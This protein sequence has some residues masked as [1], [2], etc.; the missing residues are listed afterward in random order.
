MT[1][2]SQS[3]WKHVKQEGM[4][5]SDMA[6]HHSSKVNHRM[7]RHL[8]LSALVLASIQTS[9]VSVYANEMSADNHDSEAAVQIFR[10]KG[11]TDPDE[12]KTGTNAAGA[13]ADQIS[14]SS[15]TK[16]ASTAAASENTTAEDD[17]HFVSIKG[18][19]TTDKNYA[20]DGATGTDSMVIGIGS[21]SS[22][23]NSTVIGKNNSLERNLNG[24]NDSVVVGTNLEVKGIHN[25]VFGTDYDNYDHRETKVAGDQNTVLGVGNVVGYTTERHGTEWTYTKLSDHGDDANVVVGMNNT[26]N[27]GSIV[28][29][30]SSTAGDLGTSLGHGNTI[31]GKQWGLALGNWLT[32]KGEGAVAIGGAGKWAQ[33]TVDG[34]YAIAVGANTNAKSDYTISMGYGSNAEDVC[35]ISVGYK[36]RAAGAKSIAMGLS[37]AAE[38]VQSIALGAGATASVN[39][40]IALGSLSAADRGTAN[41]V[42]W[43]PDT[44]N[45]STATSAVWKP[46]GGEFSVGNY[47][48][49]VTRQI[50]NVAAGTEDT[51]AVNV[52]QLKRAMKESADARKVINERINKDEGDSGTDTKI[53]A[54]SGKYDKSNKELNLTLTDSTGKTINGRIN[55]EDLVSS[56]SGVAKDTRNTVAAGD[57]VTIQEGTG[58]N[59]LGGI[60]YK[61]SVKADGKV[62]ENNNGLIIGSTVYNETRVSADGS[63][64]KK[65]NTAGEN[66][67]ALDM[68]VKR[69]ADGI[70]SLG[71]SVYD[72]NNR[73][74]EMDDRINKVGAGAAALAALHPL[75][76]DPKD[77]WDIAVGVGSYKNASAGALGLFYRPNERTQFNVGWTMGDNR[78]MFNAGFSVKLGRSSVYAG[79]SKADM[80][81][82]IT[83]QKDEIADLQATIGEQKKEI[84]RIEEKMNVLMARVEKN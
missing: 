44:D 48:K 12:S 75:D 23:I 79:Y 8:T 49:G 67:T 26:S 31:D 68:Q 60:E 53:D 52:A 20:N 40:G 72:L 78:N 76:Y 58:A 37:S 5:L 29:G 50:T 42:G 71:D 59:K 70:T 55:M 25:A 7:I 57:H 35:A 16:T 4:A 77:K 39:N 45:P 27:G 22:G 13:S 65:S 6:K 47:A 61:I 82:L 9:A 1:G 15:G 14:A 28:V 33:T 10:Y 84:Q 17:L 32:V 64:V 21:S 81:Q 63:Y 38:G 80:V 3:I 41:V 34:S 83:R 73:V 51:D 66:L 2:I 30:T 46:T 54:I 11:D 24:A 74:G 18:G 36:S 69:N 43:D 19:K 56:G 62:E